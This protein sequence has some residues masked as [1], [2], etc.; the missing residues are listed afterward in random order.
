MRSFNWDRTS[1]IIYVATHKSMEDLNRERLILLCLGI[2][3]SFW[4]ARSKGK[5]TA[6]KILLT[7]FVIVNR[8]YIRTFYTILSILYYTVLYILYYTFYTIL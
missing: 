3:T 8:S 7:L 5:R 1:I 2:P 4:F 6:G